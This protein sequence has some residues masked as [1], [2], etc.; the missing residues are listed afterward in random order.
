MVSVDPQGVQKPHCQENGKSFH[1]TVSISDV[2][3]SLCFRQGK[4]SL[5]PQEED[6]LCLWMLS[7]TGVLLFWLTSTDWVTWKLK[8]QFPPDSST[9]WRSELKLAHFS[10]VTVLN[11]TVTKFSYGKRL[12]SLTWFVFFKYSILKTFVP[13]NVSALLLW[14][15]MS[16]YNTDKCT[17]HF[18]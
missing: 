15:L 17:V 11:S 10:I 6:T 5:F 13:Q 8:C 9:H 3:P 14:L 2:A 16:C 1:D 7:L 18:R 12:S 4:W